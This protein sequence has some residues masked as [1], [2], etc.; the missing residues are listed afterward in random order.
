MR[1]RLQLVALILGIATTAGTSSAEEISF[2]NLKQGREAKS[3]AAAPAARKS[4]TEKFTRSRSSEKF[5][6]G[7]NESLVFVGDDPTKHIISP[8]K[9]PS[10][11]VNKDAPSSFV[12]MK[13]AYDEGDLETAHAFADQYVRYMQ[14]VMFEVRELSQMIG[15]ALVRNGV[16]D[17]ED[18]VGVSQYMGRQLAFTNANEKVSFKAT[19]EVSLERVKADSKGRAEIYVFC[20]VTSTHCREMGP[21]I[22]RIYRLTKNDPR[23][24]FG[25]FTIGAG[26]QEYLRDF[27]EYTGMTMPI[28]DGAE[29]AKQFRVSFV[30]AVVARA[31][32]ENRAYLRTGVVTF[33]RLVEFLRT[34][35]GQHP[36]MS[37]VEMQL[38]STPIGMRERGLSNSGD[39]S[40]SQSGIYTA[41]HLA[42]GEPERLHKF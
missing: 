38:V 42:S 3:Q 1:Q 21:T 30:P 14:R 10:V 31:P 28:Q 27:K 33:P 12:A 34:V 16:V 35:Q 6:G 15:E 23:V 25:V 37:D 24:K 9:T 22:E 20:S 29:L 19:A 11:R 17:E 39:S 4:L 7:I 32:T 13:K 18:W 36:A 41:S 8:D 5:N 26:Q 40:D 2:G